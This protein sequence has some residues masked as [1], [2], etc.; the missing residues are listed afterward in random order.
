MSSGDERSIRPYFRQK[1]C[2]LVAAV[3]MNILQVLLALTAKDMLSSTLIIFHPDNG[4]FIEA[5]SLNLPFN[6]QKSTYY[7][8]GVRVPAFIY[9]AM[10][11]T[12]SGHSGSKSRYVDDI[13]DV[14]DVLPTLMGYAGINNIS[15]NM[16][17]TLN[18]DGYN[19]WDNLIA[20][21]PLER[22][23][24][25]LYSSINGDVLHY[26][27]GYVAVIDNTRWKY[28]L[29]PRSGE[30]IMTM[31]RSNY[32]LEGEVLYNLDDDP[33]ETYNLVDVQLNNVCKD[34]VD[35]TKDMNYYVIVLNELREKSIDV[36]MKSIRADARATWPP[37]LR[38]FPSP[39]GC[40]L[41]LDSPLYDTFKCM[42][43]EPFIPQAWK[44]DPEE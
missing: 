44:D 41:P 18:L 2:G 7:E 8:G 15:E 30:F 25:P 20:G 11:S 32:S 26:S 4:G 38:L 19:H 13:F 34:D 42:D 1:I 12:L 40:S 5:G 14:T 43:K 36:R 29:N 27:S 10:H 9:S 24:T 6:H 33:E 21:I 22:D 17:S 28:G 39:L 3:D 35:E 31:Q 23:F 37:K 16:N